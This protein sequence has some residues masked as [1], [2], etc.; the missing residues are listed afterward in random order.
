MRHATRSDLTRIVE[1]YNSTVPTRLA[2][3][4]TIPVSVDSK[5]PWFLAHNPDKHPI[6]VHEESDIILGWISFQPFYGRPAYDQTAEISIYLAPEARGKGLGKQLLRE[7]LE[8]T[9]RLG[10]KT[11][12]GFIFSHNEPSLRLFSGFGFE[13]WGKMLNIAE[14]DG[15]EYSLSILGKR[16]TD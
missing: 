8:L 3:A 10:L 14:M 7:A 6:L 15:R 11:L 12:I 13:D 1:I 5:L 2:T 4:D 9:P 16:V